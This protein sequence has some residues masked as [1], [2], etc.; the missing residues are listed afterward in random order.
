[1]NKSVFFYLGAVILFSFSAGFS[2]E[3][4]ANA[5]VNTNDEIKHDYIKT[6]AALFRFFLVLDGLLLI[7]AGL[8]INRQSTTNNFTPLWKKPVSLTDTWTSFNNYKLA[9]V[10][11]LV[12]AVLL[13]IIS[14]NSD[15][16]I[17][18]VFTVVNFVRQ[19][20]G[21]IIT[22]FS[23]DNQHLFFSVL[24]HLS[25]NIFDESP[26]SIRLPSLLFGVASVWATMKLAAMV[27]GKRVA[28]YSGLLLTISYHHIW[29]SQNARG[30]AILLFGTVFST[31]LLLRLLES[32]KAR[33]W[34]AYALVIALSAWAHITAVFVSVAHAIV[35]LLLLIKN[36]DIKNKKWRHIFFC[37][38]GFLLAGWFTLHFYAL[39]LPQMIDFFSQP[40]AGTGVVQTE[41][42]NPLWLFN[43][44]F[45][46]MGIGTTVGWIGLLF[47]LSG[48]LVAIYLYMKHDW[49]FVLLAILP[50]LLLGITMLALGRNLW[51][52]MFLNELGFV[53]IFI[54]MTLLYISDYLRQRIKPEAYKLI[55]DI[56]VVLFTVALLSGLP[57]V[58]QYPKQDF[59]GARDFVKQNITA[60]DSV[61]GVH[62]A[63]RMFRLYY[64]KQWPEIN[65]IEE[66]NDIK[67]KQGHTWILYTLPR[68]IKATKPALYETLQ[69]DF[70]LIKVFPGT[71]GDGN[72]IVMRSKFKGSI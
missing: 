1:M 68:H 31:L 7:A 11:I 21:M 15:L 45:R 23:T 50:G 35:V 39:I 67:A 20:L 63:G 69:R 6:G 32:G 36:G 46:S 66:L 28:F 10:I 70:D 51:P 2:S 55:A 60:Y 22:D 8:Y 58:Y 72:L 34:L 37:L 38:G 3:Q 26:W 59:S 43:E 17:D 5:L 30:Y 62:M 42:R 41:W 40:G 33:Y 18:E 16:W 53:M 64:E 61:A 54:V 47:V 52:R 14:L 9:L 56:P 4:I 65:S 19:P 29:F 49:V 57:K 13:R 25:I 12:L 27:Y 48:G 71:L 24:S 44:A